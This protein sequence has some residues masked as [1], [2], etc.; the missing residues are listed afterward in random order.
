M[1]AWSHRVAY[2]VSP[3]RVLQQEAS[4]RRRRPPAAG[5]AGHQRRA[6]AAPLGRL[7]PPGAA[8]SLRSAHEVTRGAPWACLRRPFLTHTRPLPC[9][10][11]LP[12]PP[13]SMTSAPACTTSCACCPS[14]GLLRR[15]PCSPACALAVA[16]WPAYAACAM[17]RLEAAPL[18]AP[19]CGLRPPSRT[20]LLLLL[21]L[22]LPAG[23]ACTAA[24]RGPPSQKPWPSCSAASA[25]TLSSGS[26]SGDTA[27][28]RPRARLLMPLPR[29][30]RWMK[31][32]SPPRCRHACLRLSW[33][34][35]TASPRPR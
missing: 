3:I 12:P 21:L 10:G 26:D 5:A 4:A 28:M 34:G 25:T 8:C 35:T 32:A 1:T 31:R 20:P 27:R 15:I 33:P 6:D 9:L 13:C 16:G 2:A 23:W 14:S 29:R 24:P 11:P 7:Q 30:R 18:F 22:L 17:E 19:D